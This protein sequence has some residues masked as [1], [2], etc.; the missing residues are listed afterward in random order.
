LP[1]STKN[2]A[3]TISPGLGAGVSEREC[4]KPR[5]DRRHGHG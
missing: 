2:H 4:N 5:G 1:F 3:S